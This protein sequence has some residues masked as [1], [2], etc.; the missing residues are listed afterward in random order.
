MEQDAGDLAEQLTLFQPGGGG[1]DS[2]HP[3]LTSPSVIWMSH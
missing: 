3:L 2:V 1:A